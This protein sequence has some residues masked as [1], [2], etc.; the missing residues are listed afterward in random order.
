MQY[1]IIQYLHSPGH[2]DL[3]SRF[4]STCVLAVDWVVYGAGHFTSDHTHH[5]L[6]GVSMPRGMMFESRA[7]IRGVDVGFTRFLMQF[8]YQS[9]V[10]VVR[11]VCILG[12]S[13]RG[14]RRRK[15]SLHEH[16][17][18]VAL[19]PLPLSPS[20]SLDSPPLSPQDMSLSLDR[21]RYS[22]SSR[23]Q[24]NEQLSRLLCYM[25]STVHDSIVRAAILRQ[26]WTMDDS[27]YV[28]NFV[29]T[30]TLKKTV[31]FNCD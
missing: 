8:F 15:K 31:T 2:S 4:S 17:V 10:P 24:L 5:F 30:S 21:Q 22:I 28:L 3:T 1:Y 9:L 6:E 14:E 26:F 19:P 18:T 25:L 23:T 16:A 29:L 7:S 20:L 27:R 12:F 13:G 11:K